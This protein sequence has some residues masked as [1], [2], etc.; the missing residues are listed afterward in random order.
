LNA[1]FFFVYFNNKEFFW[2]EDFMPSNAQINNHEY[3][4]DNKKMSLDSNNNNNNSGKKINTREYSFFFFFVCF[5]L[6]SLN[7][8]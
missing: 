2:D 7:S 5:S 4:T 6:F 3:D 1:L 8:K